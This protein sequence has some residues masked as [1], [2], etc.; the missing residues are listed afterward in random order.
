M[1][2][3]TPP[4][5]ATPSSALLA[6]ASPSS[7]SRPAKTSRSPARPLP[8]PRS[9]EDELV[10][11]LDPAVGVEREDVDAGSRGL[12][13]AGGHHLPLEGHEIAET[14]SLARGAEDV[15]AGS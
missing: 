11:G 1:P 4:P 6:P 5:T 3:A 14:G 8:R 13:A 7:S 12:T 10:V 2:T 15:L 9:A